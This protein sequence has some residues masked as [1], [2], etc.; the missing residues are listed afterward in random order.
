MIERHLLER[1]FLLVNDKVIAKYQIQPRR[2]LVYLRRLEPGK[3]LELRYRLRATM[4]VQITVPAARV[5]EY[6][7][8]QRQGFG[9]AMRL[10]V[11]K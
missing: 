4:P 2:V 11:Q 7:N 1:Q 10:T 6:Y 8:P 3:S 9:R 5:Y